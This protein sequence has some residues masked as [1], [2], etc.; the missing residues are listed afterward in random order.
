MQATTVE[1]VLRREDLDAMGAAMQVDVKPLRV[2]AR[3]GWRLVALACGLALLLWFGVA[4]DSPRW[5]LIINGA[6]LA[7]LVSALLLY[8]LALGVQ[9]VLRIL[10][11]RHH[12]AVERHMLTIATLVG[13]TIRW[14][15]DANGLRTESRQGAREA[16]WADVRRVVVDETF[17]RFDLKPQPLLLPTDQ[18]RDDAA[19]LIR[20]HCAVDDQRAA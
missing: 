2:D 1:Y 17:W 8:P 15:F 6:F 10:V 18:M 19:A 14:T 16:A 5:L 3:A 13:T 11:K 4:M 12:R 20:A 7:L 9:A